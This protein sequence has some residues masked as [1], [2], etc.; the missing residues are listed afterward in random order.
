RPS[1]GP[2]TLPAGCKPEWP[3]R[4]IAVPTGKHSPPAATD[5]GYTGGQ[6]L[7]AEVPSPAEAA[8]PPKSGLS[9]S[10]LDVANSARHAWRSAVLQAED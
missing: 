6:A 5:R 2:P 8:S 1:K 4:S 7:A 3:Q 9:D 10:P